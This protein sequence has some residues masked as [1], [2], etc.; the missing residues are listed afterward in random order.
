DQ[1]KFFRTKPL[2]FEKEAVIL[3][4]IPENKKEKLESLKARMLS[5]PSIKSVSFSLGAPTSDNNFGTNYS[6]TER[7]GNELFPVGVKP[8]DRDYMETYG[9]E[10]KAGRWFNESDEK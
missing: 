3:V 5:N 2:G 9:I 6:L 10:L 7:A 4:D 1:M 8:A